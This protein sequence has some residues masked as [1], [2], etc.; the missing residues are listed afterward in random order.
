M[1]QYVICTYEPDLSD[2]DLWIASFKTVNGRLIS[3]GKVE[4][5]QSDTIVLNR[6][7]LA[8]LLCG[9]PS[10]FADVTLAILAAKTF[11]HGSE[12][13]IS[14]SF[15]CGAAIGT[16]N[17][18]SSMDASFERKKDCWGTSKFIF[19]MGLAVL[20]SLAASILAVQFGLS[21]SDHLLTKIISSVFLALTTF[22]TTIGDTMYGIQHLVPYTI[23]Y[24][25]RTEYC[26]ELS[27]CGI[28]P[29]MFPLLIAR[30]I[31]LFFAYICSAITILGTGDAVYNFFND[32]SSVT[33][34]GEHTNYTLATAVNFS[35]FFSQAAWLIHFFSTMENALIAYTCG[36]RLSTQDKWL[37]GTCILFTLGFGY[38]L[39]GA[40]A[41][42]YENRMADFFGDQEQIYKLPWMIA[43]TVPALSVA[44]QAPLLRTTGTVF[45]KL[46]EAAGNLFTDISRSGK[47]KWRHFF[48]VGENQPLLPNNRDTIINN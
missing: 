20:A 30:L 40:C 25:K 44:I 37:Y 21:V 47:S 38:A 39:S 32:V 28:P 15:L 24:L 2:P 19:S 8:S 29:V 11:H 43:G 26:D 3:G 34:W 5:H 45:A 42:N 35:E 48:G 33:G 6:H 16:L 12:M 36:K 7:T 10:G 9:F 27:Y 31:M 17:A 13:K 23:D 14:M 4:I 41:A 46:F 22:Y 18:A 1:S